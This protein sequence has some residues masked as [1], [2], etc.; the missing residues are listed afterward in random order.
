MSPPGVEPQFYARRRALGGPRWWSRSG[1][2][3]PVKR[4]HLLVEALVALKPTHPQLRAVIAG[5]GYERPALEAL[6]HRAG[7]ES[8]I[9]P[10]RLRSRG[11]S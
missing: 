4:F 10:P 3:V 9:S 2:L 5:E 8:W 11:R 6:I 7:A 1:R